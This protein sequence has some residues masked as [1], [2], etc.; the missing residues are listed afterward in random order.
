MT[1]LG[2]WRTHRPPPTHPARRDWFVISVGIV[3]PKQAAHSF[4]VAAAR[5]S[6]YSKTLIPH[7]HLY[8]ARKSGKDY[9]RPAQQHSAH[10][11]EKVFTFSASTSPQET[12]TECSAPFVDQPAR[13]AITHSGKPNYDRKIFGPAAKTW[14][15]EKPGKRVKKRKK[16]KKNWLRTHD[17]SRNSTWWPLPETATAITLTQ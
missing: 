10:F 4:G 13:P 1:R 16:K 14:E 7:N 12:A 5:A 8:A 9:A 2:K 3:P 17:R 11:P 15:F 6:K